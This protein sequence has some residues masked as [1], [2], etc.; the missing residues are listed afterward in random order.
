MNGILDNDK[1]W[2]HVLQNV[3]VAIHACCVND[4]RG[5]TNSPC[6]CR[7]TVINDSLSRLTGYT[8]RD[9]G[10]LFHNRISEM[11]ILEDR[12]D[13]LCAIDELYEY[14]HEK[15]LIFRVRKKNGEI[16]LLQEKICS[17][18]QADGSI[19]LYAVMVDAAHS[20]RPANLMAM[21]QE[22]EKRVQIRTFG[23][24]NVVVD[25][26]P[27]AFQH[28][29][30]KELLALLVDRQGKY[31]SSSE[32]ISCLWEDEP[33]SDHTRSRCRKAAFYLKETLDKYGLGDLMESTS[34]GYR[35]IRTEMI[36]CDLYHYLADE[37]EYVRAF[38][39]VYIADYSWAEQT[40]TSLMYKNNK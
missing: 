19:W 36:D 15:S 22:G 25:G 34:K 11:V 4:R 39:G 6:N 13:Y 29:K 33:A 32:I 24:F 9:I 14:P 1:R 37:P 27:I 12:E 3:P 20:K 35:R 38:R 40:L 31:V 10:L 30:A 8:A 5:E 16:I 28:E 17:V 26:K 21:Q 2:I 7:S 23:Y 18:R